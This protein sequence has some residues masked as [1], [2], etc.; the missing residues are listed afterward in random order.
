MTEK[1]PKIGIVGG[2]A[3]GLTYAVFL[4]PVADVIIKTHGQTQ[5]DHIN[6]D[7]I[8]VTLAGQT[9]RTD[10]IAASAD[11]AALQNCDGVIVALKSYDTKAV[12]KELAKVTRQDVPVISLQNGL[13]AFEILQ[14]TIDNPNRVFAGVTYIGAKRSD[15]RSVS[16]G[17]NRRTVIDAK[18]GPI[19]DVFTKTRFGVEA[20]DNIR[21][22]VWDKMVLN[23]GQNA[24]SAITNLSVKQMLG[25]AECIAIAA[26]LLNELEKVG[27]TEGLSFNYSLLEKLKDNWSGG[28][29]FYPSMWQDLHAGKRTEIDAINGAISRLGS[30]HSIATPY[31]DMITSLMK[32]LEKKII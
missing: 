12:A 19:L 20:S 25:S 6:T 11:M 14:Q 13:E 3:V 26:E 4:A 1:K 21:Q 22:A 31:N 16:L 15:D 10:G 32:V 9:E 7:G 27:K 30:K 5:A 29:D 2:G 8:E 23:N 17:I 24:L 28:L 18:A